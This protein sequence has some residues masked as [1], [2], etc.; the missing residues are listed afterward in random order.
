M[1]DDPDA[2]VNIRFGGWCSDWPSGNGFFP[3][4]F[5]SD[6]DFWAHFAE[7]AVDAEIERIAKLPIDQQPA[8]WG[9]L[10]QLI[11]TDYYPVVVTGYLGS[12]LLHG[13]RI[14]GMNGDSTIGMPTW[15]DIH[16]VP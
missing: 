13:S 8:E 6:S 11:M 5:R 7:P 2:P 4:L 12:A 16:V 1:N 14:G 9:A 15:K 10:D 3:D